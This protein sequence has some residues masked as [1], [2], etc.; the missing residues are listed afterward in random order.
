MEILV[1]RPQDIV[2]NVTY[3]NLPV[4]ADATPTATVECTWPE[5]TS[6][7]GTVTKISTGVYK[8]NVL[9]SEVQYPKTITVTWEFSLSGSP[10]TQRQYVSVVPEYS[11]VEELLIVSPDSATLGEVLEASNF[12]RVLIETVTHQKF[13]PR[14]N[15]YTVRGS[16]TDRL[17]LPERILSVSKVARGQ[18]NLLPTYS[19]S[20]TDTNYG[21]KVYDPL[22][23]PDLVA[24]GILFP[25]TERFQIDGVF[26][27]ETV[28][29]D[30]SRAHKLLVNDW[31]CGDTVFAK[32]YVHKQK[33]ADWSSELLTLAF[34][35]TGNSFADRLLAPYVHSFMAV[36]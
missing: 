4:D 7:A 15:S 34:K 19:C 28:P 12:A 32:K 21:I 2:L 30:V 26:G 1:S 11:T 10:V 25:K 6:R 36:I 23:D 20:I 27:W 5:V 24:Q 8:V 3:N 29:P 22:L 13:Y 31:F 33:A 16:G 17:L 14:F 9:Y 18:E 35:D